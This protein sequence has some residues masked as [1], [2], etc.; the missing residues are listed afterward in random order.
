M[1]FFDGIMKTL[2]KLWKP[3]MLESETVPMPTESEMM[4]EQTANNPTSFTS[5][6]AKYDEMD[7]NSP[8]ACVALDVLADLVC[9]GDDV[10]L[11]GHKVIVDVEKR[12]DK[13]E[14]EDGKAIYNMYFDAKKVKPILADRINTIILNFESRTKIKYKLRNMVRRALKYGDD[15][16]QV[17]FGKVKGTEELRVS[18]FYNYPVT[19]VE[20][21]LDEYGR[22]DKEYP[23]KVK[24]I[25]TQKE[26]Y[27]RKEEVF[28]IQFGAE[29][30]NKRGKSLFTA[31]RKTYTRLDAMI[32]GMVIG[33][34]V[35]S[36]QRYLFKVD[37]TGM[38][39]DKALKYVEQL[40]N[41][42]TKKKITDGS[43]FI[44]H[45]KAPLSADEDIWYPTRKDRNDGVEV[46]ENDPY[47]NNIG[48]IQ[49]VYNEYRM[50]LRMPASIVD[51]TGSRNATAEQETYPIRFAKSVQNMLRLA[52]IDLYKTELKNHGIDEYLIE[53]INIEMAEIDSVSTVRKFG[54][55]RTRAEVVKIHSDAKVVS[56][57]YLLENVMY[58]SEEEIT[59]IEREL[60]Q[61]A[62]DELEQDKQRM[63]LESEY[64]SENTSADPDYKNSKVRVKTEYK[65][66]KQNKSG[67][68]YTTNMQ[69]E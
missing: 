9:Q 67:N 36:H 58:L 31:L 64:S 20:L 3:E 26:M 63:E 46:L 44:K 48:D 59:E 65:N 19:Q 57:R 17:L 12:E 60:E 40:K 47:L 37:V 18:D 49:F 6:I 4:M 55:E 29:N 10:L 42:H 30:E 45:I 56:R 8:E 54:I 23:Y 1:M 7:D 16:N 5:N 21:N 32:E 27:L 69:A 53:D 35:R 14:T 28:R 34:L 62:A 15:F 43:G 51:T 22:L 61:E 41:A 66:K 2:I 24:S 13:R 50:G 33:R 11:R 39:P 38:A 52:L 68:A 25:T